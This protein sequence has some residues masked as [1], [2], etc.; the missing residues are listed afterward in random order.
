MSVC[1]PVTLTSHNHKSPFCPRKYHT[2]N[3]HCLGVPCHAAGYHSSRFSVLTAV[4]LKNHI[5]WHMMLC[6]WISSSQHF[7][8]SW[9]VHL[10]SQ[11]E[12]TKIH[13]GNKG[14]TVHWNIRHCLP[15]RAASY[16]RRLE[17]SH[18]PVAWTVVNKSINWSC[19]TLQPKLVFM[20]LLLLWCSL[21]WALVMFLLEYLS[22][23]RR[24][25]I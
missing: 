4:L 15:N 25:L 10:Q 20:L 22:L 9:C 23:W 1:S 19:F 16:P 8:G 17:S 14:T 18:L 3:P 11:A 5:F 6:H 24:C 2:I 21:T 12:Q 7:K 13:C